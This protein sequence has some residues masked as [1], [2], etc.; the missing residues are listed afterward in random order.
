MLVLIQIERAHTK[1]ARVLLPDV[2]VTKS[3]GDR[4]KVGPSVHVRVPALRNQFSQVLFFSIANAY[5]ENQMSSQR[6][7]GS[8]MITLL[9]FLDF[10]CSTYWEVS[11][12][13][14]CILHRQYT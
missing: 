3:L 2:E 1:L 8:V 7:G 6:W 9:A 10:F 12:F 11:G 5:I 14:V 13:N 4:S